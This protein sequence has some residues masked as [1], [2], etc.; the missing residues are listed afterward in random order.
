MLGYLAGSRTGAVTYNLL[1]HRGVSIVI[2]II[3]FVYG[4]EVLQLTGLIMFGHSSVD[5]IFGY[6]M[7]FSDSFF[8]T[9]LGQLP[10]GGK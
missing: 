2:Y 9:H 3:G 8:N 7:K 4:S 10:R 6:G 1:H 5:R